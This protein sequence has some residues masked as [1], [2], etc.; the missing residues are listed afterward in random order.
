[1]SPGRW[2]AR[3]CVLALS[4]AVTLVVTSRLDMDPDPV[5][6]VLLT[7]VVVVLVGLLLDAGPP[8]APTWELEEPHLGEQHRRDPHTAANLRILQHHL[9]MDRAD[10]ALRDR[11]A[12]L[13]EQVL[14]VRHG[15]PPETARAYELMGPELTG[16]V[17]DPPRRLTREEIERCVHRIETL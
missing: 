17:N 14:M 9:A 15:E 3:L 4:A 11:L 6:V 8:P 5:R 2:W 7:A 16:V 13:A 12:Q 10:S 1:M